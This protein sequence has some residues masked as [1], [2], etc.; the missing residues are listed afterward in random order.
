[1]VHACT[2]SQI[3]YYNSL[4]YNLPKKQIYRLQKLMNS[5]VRFIFNIKNPRTHITPF[6]KKCHLLPVKLRVEFKICVLI[7]KCINNSAPNYLQNLISLKDCLPSLRIYID[8]TLLHQPLLDNNFKSRRFSVA[9]PKL[10]NEL[11][12]NLRELNTISSFKSNLK[13]HLFSKF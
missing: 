9:G 10:W 5:C 7:Y 2:I 6:L 8:A 12:K 13:T 11:P 4:Y 3:D 1:M